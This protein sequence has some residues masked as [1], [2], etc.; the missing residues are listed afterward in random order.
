MKSTRKS[1]FK[2]TWERM[3]PHKH[4]LPSKAKPP[5]AVLADGTKIS[6]CEHCNY[7]IFW[8]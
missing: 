3:D 4:A 1:T 6:F 8:R 5:E 2:F 7:I